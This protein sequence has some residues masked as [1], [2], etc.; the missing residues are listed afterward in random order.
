M[1]YI[2][3][4]VIKLNLNLHKVDIGSIITY[5]FEMSICKNDWIPILWHFE[6]TS[7][8]ETQIKWGPVM[9][10]EPEPTNTR[11]IVG[12]FFFFFTRS[13][14]KDVPPDK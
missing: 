11:F 14:K 3:V 12:V 1:G 5:Y 13:G 9:T 2:I 4:L 6:Y 8:I 10:F 7:V